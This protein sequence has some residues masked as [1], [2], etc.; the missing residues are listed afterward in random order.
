MQHSETIA[1]VA[2]PPGRGGIGVIRVS[3]PQVKQVAQSV[4]GKLP[5]PRLAS[6][7]DFRASGGEH[8]DQGLAL[9]FP[10]PHSFTGEDVL[11]LHAH[12]G[13]VLLAMLLQNIISVSDTRLARPGEFSER[14]FLNGKLDLLQAEAIADLIDAASQQAVRCAA[15]SLQ[16]EFSQRIKSLQAALV[17]MRVSVEAAIDFPEEEIDVL[18]QTELQQQLSALLLQLQ[19]LS[20]NAQ[21]GALLREGM[22]VVI[23]GQANVG[24]SSL[25]NRL[26][27][28]ELAIVSPIA[29]TTRDVLRQHILLHGMP[30]YIMDTA[31]IRAAQDSIE[32]QGIER[33]ARQMAQAD[34][35]LWVC[36]SATLSS[37][38]SEIMAAHIPEGSAV[39]VVLNKIDLREQP[40]GMDEHSHPP[41]V[42]LSAK[43]GAGID[44]LREHLAA[45]MGLQEIAGEGLLLA[46]QRHTDALNRAAAILQDACAQFA[47]NCAAELLAEDLRQVQ[48]CLGEITGEYSSDD[49]LGAIFS[50]FCIGK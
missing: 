44:L 10:A 21:Q 42:A 37:E 38:E 43:T 41:R 15:R 31:G 35:I 33:T 26:A 7:S 50:Q 23:A 11:E 34:R 2:T 28:E 36:A 20:R 49:L 5:A 29:G 14:A 30:V 3:G 13:P 47:G 45:C 40:A 19:E 32:Q 39:T 8:I 6:L 16:G 27:G 12:G 48:Q 9:Y 1:A 46:R 4:L 17:N 24:K 22:R 25:L 18:R